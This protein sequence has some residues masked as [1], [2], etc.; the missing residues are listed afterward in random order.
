MFH[1]SPSIIIT[2][3]SL[4]VYSMFKAFH[5]F[6]L[7]TYSLPLNF[8]LKCPITESTFTPNFEK[9]I[10]YNFLDILRY[11]LEVFGKIEEKVLM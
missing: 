8:Y 7:M 4:I 3:E 2:S 9:R 5:P 11:H 1:I 10:L 6:I